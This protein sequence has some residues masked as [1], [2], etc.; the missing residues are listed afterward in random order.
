MIGT[1]CCFADNRQVEWERLKTNL[2]KYGENMI[3]VVFQIGGE[4]N[5]LFNNLCFGIIAS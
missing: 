4:R 5:R 3:R 2:N 1:E